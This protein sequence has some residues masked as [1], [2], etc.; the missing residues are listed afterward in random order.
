MGKLALH[1]ICKD[2]AHVIGKMLESA[3][4]IT[5]LIVANDTGSTDGTQDIIKKFG[6]DNNIPTY[7]FERPFDNFENSRNHSMEKLREVATELKWDLDKSHGF[8]FDCDETLVF[9]KDFKKNQ[10][11]KDLYMINTYI[12]QMKYTRNTFFKLSKPFKWYGP[13]HEFIICDEKKISSG[14]AEGVHVAVEMTGAS[15][16]GDVPAKYKDHAFKLE[17][18]V[19]NDR[20]DPRWLFYTA[21]SYHDS[22]T[23][24]NN[25]LENEE[26][27]RRASKY[28]KERVSR[29]DGY[30]EERYYAQFRVGAISMRLEEPWSKTKTELLKAYSIEPMRAESIKMIIDY[31]V[32]MSEWDMAYLYSKFAYETFHGN[33][34]Y[35]KKLLFIDQ[36]LYIWKIAEIHAAAAFYTKRVDESKKAFKKVLEALKTNPETFNEG[37]IQKIETNKKFFA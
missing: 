25:K 14:L 19:D 28:Y 6:E 34:P 36:S 13:V 5:D 15:W 20:S 32:K 7:V 4:T 24:P 12:K 8:W 29:P 9:D 37:D 21:Q 27:L 1:F 16:Q 33:N 30:P 26:R 23:I 10:F 17:A 2:E 3:K 22:A 18:Y 31:Y 35:P 11:T